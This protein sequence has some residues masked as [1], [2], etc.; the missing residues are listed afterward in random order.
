MDIMDI[1]DVLASAIVWHST[2]DLDAGSK[3]L[4]AIHTDDDEFRL[5][6]EF[7]LAEAGERSFE[8]ILDGLE[9]GA[10]SGTEAAHLLSATWPQ[11]VHHNNALIFSAVGNA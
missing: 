2:G 4:A 6:A 5:L 8:L 7:M 1:V 3:L 9:S 11:S 10:I